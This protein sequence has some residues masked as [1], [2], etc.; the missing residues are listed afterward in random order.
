MITV[1]AV[2]F[3]QIILG[4]YIAFAGRDLYTFYHLCGR[5]FPSMGVL[6]DQHLGG[7]IVW[8]PASMMSSAAFMLVLNNLRRHEEIDP[9]P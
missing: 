8:I 1:V 2:M 9:A 3:P 6:N 4:S 7:L 5:L